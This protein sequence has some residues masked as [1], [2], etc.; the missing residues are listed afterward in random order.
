MFF[1]VMLAIRHNHNGTTLVLQDRL[2]IQ[3]GFPDDSK[4]SSCKSASVS[5]PTSMLPTTGAMG[6]NA[7]TAGDIRPTVA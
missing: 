2:F 6:E 4:K 1:K 5:G 7:L 3:K